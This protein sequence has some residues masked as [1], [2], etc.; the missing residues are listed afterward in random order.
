MLCD[1]SGDSAEYYGVGSG[2]LCIPYA[3]VH[4]STWGYVW[5]DSWDGLDQGGNYI[6]SPVM[7]DQGTFD[8][9]GNTPISF[10][11][12]EPNP[13]AAQLFSYNHYADNGYGYEVSRIPND[14]IEY[15]GRTF[16]QYTSVDT[17]VGGNSSVDGSRFAGVAYS[18]DYGDTWTDFSTQWDGEHRGHNG[19]LYQ[20]WTFAGI[21][22]GY[23]YIF[24]KAWNGSHNFNADNSQII[25]WR[26]TTTN[27]YNGTFSS[28][29]NWHKTGSTWGWSSTLAATPIFASGNDLGEFSVKKIGSTW[30][31]SYLDCTDYS[32]KTRTASSV[33]GTWS[34]EKIQVVG[35]NTWP[36]AHWGKPQQ[37]NLYGGYIHP[38]S[39][40]TSNLCLII[41]QWNGTV[42]ARPYVATQWTG[43]SA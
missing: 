10:T 21:D 32:I 14:C 43:L 6:G 15:N 35:N 37:P 2:D 29:E 30:V 26:M 18:D 36:P 1:N 22:S 27:F 7:L 24:S 11:W 31:M 41:S 16:L 8:S 20:M 3:R 39:A 19:S 33:T 4:D 23:V 25:L 17:W 42:G 12:A 5:G 28:V 40:S 38:G 9:S 34:A 13:Q